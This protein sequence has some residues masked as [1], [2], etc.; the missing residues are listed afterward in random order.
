M[1]IEKGQRWEAKNPA[2][3]KEEN[4][5]D[6]FIVDKVIQDPFEGEVILCHGNSTSRG[7][8]KLS[9]HYRFLMDFVINNYKLKEPQ[10]KT[11]K[12]KL[13]GC[14]KAINQFK[15]N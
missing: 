13:S 1:K 7:S 9:N 2:Q 4:Y 8:G 5:P 14:L 15:R 6:W 10:P 3:S 12:Q 11:L